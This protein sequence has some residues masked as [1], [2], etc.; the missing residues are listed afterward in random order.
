MQH[1]DTLDLVIAKVDDVCEE[2]E[3]VCFDYDED[4]LAFVVEQAAR[5]D[6]LAQA[7]LDYVD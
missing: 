7:A 2:G 1:G 4:A 5:G 3:V 6:T